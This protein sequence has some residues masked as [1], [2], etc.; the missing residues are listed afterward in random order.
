[1]A[2]PARPCSASLTAIALALG[3]LL[4]A[5]SSCPQGRRHEPATS[6][7]AGMIDAFPHVRVDRRAG[8]VEFDGI[9]PVDAHDPRTPLVFLEQFVCCPDSREY[10][11][12]VV[13][14]ARP[15]HVHAALLLAGARAGRP[16]EWRWVN[17]P[18]PGSEHLTT[19]APEGTPLRMTFRWNDAE[20]R[21]REAP[22]A[23]WVK[24][25]PSGAPLTGTPRAPLWVFA[26]SR[27]VHR[28]GRDYYD[29]DM[30]GELVGLTTFGGETVSWYEVLSPDAAVQE[31]EW[32]AD[33]D[34]VPAYAT[35]VT[36]VL[37]LVNAGS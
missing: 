2:R 1:M 25:H 11:S 30:T 20:G 23:A 17:E 10:E 22:A 5:D 35:P 29:A 9:V 32:I 12:L 19:R 8:I 26:G 7:P 16:G 6:V 3:A 28:N 24:L 13:T 33:A 34:I 4:L 15:S 21:P 18:A 36:V 27:I 31:P 37:T 14:K